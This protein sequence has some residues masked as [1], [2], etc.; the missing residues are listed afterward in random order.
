[1]TPSDP[2][3]SR[4]RNQQVTCSSHV[5]GS[6]SFDNFHFHRH[7]TSRAFSR[8][9]L[10]SQDAGTG[11]G[12]DGVLANVVSRQFFVTRQSPH[13]LQRRRTR[14]WGERDPIVDGLTT[15]SESPVSERSAL[16]ISSAVG[17]YERANASS[18][19]WLSAACN[20]AI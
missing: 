8:I 16:P 19:P 2:G 17:I 18:G 13:S 12:V 11:G 10:R 5:A 14:C 15:L 3:K 1:M 9:A 7:R 20:A 4:L 6:T